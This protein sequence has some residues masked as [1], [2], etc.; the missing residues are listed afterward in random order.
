MKSCLD[1]IWSV[2][3]IEKEDGIY[4]YEGDC[5][6]PNTDLPS[7]LWDYLEDDIDNLKDATRSLLKTTATNC[8][9]YEQVGIGQ[10]E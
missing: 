6:H 1:C 3:K 2:L 10:P 9:Y 4:S 5:N 7:E 8:E